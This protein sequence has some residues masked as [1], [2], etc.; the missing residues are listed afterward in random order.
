MIL[1]LA[2]LHIDKTNAPNRDKNICHLVYLKHAEIGK[3][4]LLNNGPSVTS[5]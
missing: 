4:Y 3:I 2:N 1:K 5:L